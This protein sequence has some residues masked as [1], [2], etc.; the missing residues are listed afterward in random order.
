M[1]K[2]LT[3]KFFKNDSGREPVRE[4]LKGLSAKNRKAI[5]EDIKTVQYG[6]PV[7]MPVVSSIQGQ[8]GMWEIRTNLDNGIARILFTIKGQYLIFLNGIIKKS[9]KTPKNAIKVA[10]LRMK[11][12]KIKEIKK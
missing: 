6:W 1:E 10:S 5:G 8:P 3:I 7:G 2:K 9:Q 4:W 11:K 12:I